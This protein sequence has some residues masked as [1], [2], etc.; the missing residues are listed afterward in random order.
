MTSPEWGLPR[1][2]H[3]AAMLDNGVEAG[4]L[5][6]SHGWAVFP[7][8]VA[9]ERD[10][11]PACRSLP[12]ERVCRGKHDQARGALDYRAATLAPDEWRRMALDVM[13]RHEVPDVNIACSP[14]RCVV[15]LVGID[16][17]GPEAVA[18]F[19]RVNPDFDAFLRVESSG[20]G[21]GQHVYALGF[22]EPL[23]GTHRWGGEVRAARGHLMLPPSL[24][25]GRRDYYRPVGRVLRQARDTKGLT[26]ARRGSAGPGAPSMTS[27]TEIEEVLDRL[28][29]R[30]PSRSGQARLAGKLAALAEAAPGSRYPSMVSAVACAVWLARQGGVPLRWAL[31]TITNVYGEAVAGEGRDPGS[32]T[33]AALGWV[34]GQEFTA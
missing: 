11:C 21:G 7:V 4:D 28:S 26:G 1:A 17:D 13:S 16:L 5:L 9:H 6:A 29:L 33:Y 24:V 14:W 10:T 8:P 18:G 2:L 3:E 32:Q 12:A 34:L 30:P 23:A 31:D 19:Y 25:E 15:P 27:E 22:R 20:K